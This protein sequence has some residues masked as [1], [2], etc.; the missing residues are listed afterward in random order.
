MEKQT[1]K[2]DRKS[3][4]SDFVEF[5]STSKKFF[6]IFYF[7]ISSRSR[8]V[9]SALEEKIQKFVDTAKKKIHQNSL[10]FIKIRVI[11]ISFPSFNAKKLPFR[12]SQKQGGVLKKLLICGSWSKWQKFAEA[13]EKL[14]IFNFSN[15]SAN[16]CH[17]DQ[18]PHN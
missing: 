14:K 5:F 17:F 7:C 3:E 2:F 10:K 16:F 11:F 15:A 1:Q 9:L 12:F 18:L 13:F 8:W 4:K 6:L